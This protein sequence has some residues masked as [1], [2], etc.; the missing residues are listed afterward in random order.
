MSIAEMEEDRD[1]PKRTI[2]ANWAA[3]AEHGTDRTPG[4]PA[5]A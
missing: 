3:G 1:D 2:H 5:K 4:G